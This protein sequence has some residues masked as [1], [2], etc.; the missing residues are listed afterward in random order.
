MITFNDAPGPYDCPTNGKYKF[1][2]KGKTLRFKRIHDSTSGI[3]IARVI[4][5]KHKFTKI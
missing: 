1:M 5:L 4:F 2:L 3:C